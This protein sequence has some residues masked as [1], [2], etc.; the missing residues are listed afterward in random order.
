MVNVRAALA[1]ALSAA[2]GLA[3]C[4]AVL[5]LD[6]LS[7]KPATV[8]VDGDVI[9]PGDGGP[10]TCTEDTVDAARRPAAQ[11]AGD[12]A[13][14]FAFN[15]LQIAVSA[16][17]GFDLDHVATVDAKTSSCAFPQGVSPITDAPGGVDNGGAALFPTVGIVA[18]ALSA[19]AI[20]DRLRDAQFGVL[21]G[22]G[23]WNGTLTDDS[24][25][26]LV[27][28]TLGI[29]TENPGASPTPGGPTNPAH[30]T[31]TGDGAPTDRWMRD[32]RFPTGAGAATAA[33]VNG[34]R[35]VARFDTLTLPI[36]PDFD[37][38][39]LDLVVRDAWIT[40]DLGGDK[41]QPTLRNG[42]IAG[43]LVVSD[44][45]ADLLLLYTG[46]EYLCRQDRFPD[47][48]RSRICAFRD[49]RASHCDD[50][51]ALPCD[52]LSFSAR[53]ETYR[54]DQLGPVFEQTAEVYASAGLL[55]PPERC[56]DVDIDGGSR[57]PP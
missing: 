38:K 23:G 56:K 43:R 42:V 9:D 10:T 17:L 5:G 12:E 33:W 21:L 53:F 18:P 37:L 30:R 45:L 31:I 50:K 8:E 39:P 35:L 3:A 34:G 22:L 51:K 29:W 11:G 26:L 19:K 49:I 46:Q 4:N 36:R 7:E 32:A 27:F 41:D 52:A 40:G 14:Y 2:L 1:L 28:P 47:L 24:L 25:T 16:D 44:F 57:C 54:V 55:A 48:A 20:V 13:R 15:D 6:K